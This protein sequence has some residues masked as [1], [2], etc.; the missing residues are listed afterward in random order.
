MDVSLVDGSVP[1]STQVPCFA[2]AIAAAF[3][4]YR[5]LI[6]CIGLLS[7]CGYGL[8]LS[9]RAGDVEA[10]VFYVLML[11]VLSVSIMGLRNQKPR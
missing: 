9:S 8:V 7:I 1:I 2:A 10:I 5:P 3:Y 4:F 11:L 6:G